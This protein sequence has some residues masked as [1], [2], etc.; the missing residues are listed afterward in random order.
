MND[1]LGHLLMFRIPSVLYSRK[2]LTKAFEDN[3]IPTH[4]LPRPARLDKSFNKACSIVKGRWKKQVDSN[5]NEVRVTITP[6]ESNE[7]YIQ[8]DVVQECVRASL[9]TDGKYINEFNG[10]VIKLI[11]RKDIAKATPESDTDRINKVMQIQ[12]G[13]KTPDELKKDGTW[14][15]G[16]DYADIAQDVIDTLDKLQNKVDDMAVRKAVRTTIEG[17]CYGNIYLG[18]RG[19]YLIPHDQEGRMNKLKK[20]LSDLGIFCHSVP[21]IDTADQRKQLQHYLSNDLIRDINDF[22]VELE[23]NIT[24]GF[25]RKDTKARMRRELHRYSTMVSN[26]SPNMT[27]KSEAQKL[28]GAVT[29]ARIKFGATEKATELTKKR[30]EKENIRKEESSSHVKHTHR[31]IV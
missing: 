15:P 11:L 5:G 23:D 8:K 28:T 3:D 24:S 21:I 30:R 14:A 6:V 9:D 19:V 20:A 7:K 1:P 25:K 13:G 17:Y 18:F 2:E 10:S 31:S 22:I 27:N 29:K 26:F 4:P 12:T 16:I